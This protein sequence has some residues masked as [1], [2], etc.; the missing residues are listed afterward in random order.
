MFASHNG[1]FG[2]TPSNKIRFNVCRSTDNGLTWSNPKNLS[3][4]IYDNNWNAAWVASG[5]AHQMRSGRI[6]A[7]VGVRPSTSNILENHMIY[8]DDG[9]VSWGSTNG[10][11]NTAGG[12]NESKI[13]ELDNGDLL[14]NLRSTGGFRKTAIS[15]DAGLT[16]S[17][18]LPET[19]LI[20]PGVN[21]DLIRYTSTLDG[22]DKSRLLFSNPK[23]SS[24]RQNLHVF[25][26]NDEGATWPKATSRLIYEGNS[27]Y[28]SLTILSDGTIGLYYENGEFEAYQLS[29]ARFSLG[30]LSRGTDQFIP[31]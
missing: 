27:A 18:S 17:Y 26:S 29:F 23:Q 4:Q 3:D 31:K 30:W 5:S 8:S 12:G 10:T 25:L 19:Q 6:I 20:D 14:M 9:G 13:V 21:A 22:Y 11:P 15:E 24:G 2:S 7:V 16:W 28:S 1:L